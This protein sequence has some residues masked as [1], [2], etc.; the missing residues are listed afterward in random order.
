[1]TTKLLAVLVA[2]VSFSSITYAASVTPSSG[3]SILYVNGQPAADKLGKNDLEDG[4]N[5]I[6]VRMDKDMARSG[7]SSSDVFTS[8]PYVLTIEKVSGD[9]E[10][11]H[12]QARSMMEAKKAFNSDQPKWLVEQ[13]GKVINYQQEVLQGKSG[14]FPYLGMEKL[15]AEHNQAR[16][17]YFNG[18]KAVDKPVAVEAMA[19]T[20][21]EAPVAKQTNKVVTTNIE[22]LKAWY[23]KSSADERKA[24]RKWIIDQE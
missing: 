18:G 2:A 23:L 12:P 8:K 20:A 14:L 24:F 1:M 17:V 13:D 7:A 10:I 16:G 21:S 4:L 22:Q 5:Q 15:V 9:L 19:V 3:V 6:V 11:S